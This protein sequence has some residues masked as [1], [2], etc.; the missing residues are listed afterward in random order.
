MTTRQSLR[1]A[2]KPC[3]CKEDKQDRLIK[4]HSKEPGNCP[5]NG[6]FHEGCIE[7]DR[8]EEYICSI[9]IENEET[10]ELEDQAQGASTQDTQ[11]DHDFSENDDAEN[12]QSGE[13][14]G[15]NELS[16]EYFKKEIGEVRSHHFQRLDKNNKDK[17][18]TTFKIKWQNYDYVSYDGW[19]FLMRLGDQSK[20]K[21]GA[22]IKSLPPRPKN[23]L[24]RRVPD[25]MSLLKD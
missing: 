12:D 13:E 24:L 8:P 14:A 1:I 6:F 20:S 25:L 3:I 19:Q 7:A 17:I 22:Y 5:G 18:F 2:R 10:Q 15:G 9:C 21:L 23:T 4:C 16:L 11:I